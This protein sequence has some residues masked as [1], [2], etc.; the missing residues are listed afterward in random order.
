MRVCAD[1]EYRPSADVWSFG[2]VMWE[3]Y[4]GGSY[5]Y[6]NITEP[7]PNLHPQVFLQEQ[8]K[9]LERLT[10]YIIATKG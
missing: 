5:P 2:V 1:T 10:N 8:M 3:I 9:A 7:K 6:S 4:S